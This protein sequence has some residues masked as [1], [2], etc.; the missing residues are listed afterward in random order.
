MLLTRRQMAE[1]LGVSRQ[2]Y[3]NWTGRTVTLRTKNH[4][5][6]KATLRKMLD[7]LVT[8]QWVLADVVELDSKER[9]AKLLSMLQKPEP[10]EE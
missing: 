9:Y 10:T 4:G 3:Y 5:H 1:L 8:E 6:V 7:L 2:T